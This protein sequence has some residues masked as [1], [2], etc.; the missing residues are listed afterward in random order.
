MFNVKVFPEPFL[1]G[2]SVQRP[3]F[4]LSGSV[5]QRH[6]ER[7]PTVWVVMSG[8]NR[9]QVRWLAVRLG[10]LWVVVVGGGL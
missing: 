3:L 7:V 10:T 5:E 6:H 2:R 9:S 4:P 8:G 1:S